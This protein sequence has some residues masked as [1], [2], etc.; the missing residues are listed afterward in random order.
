[1]EQKKTDRGDISKLL[2]EPKEAL[3]TLTMTVKFGN[4]Q[5]KSRLDQVPRQIFSNSK[6]SKQYIFKN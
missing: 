4:S 3:Q 5:A 6:M 1:M 2:D